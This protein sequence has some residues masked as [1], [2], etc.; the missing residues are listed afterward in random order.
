MTTDAI[1]R[2]PRCCLQHSD[3]QTLAEHLRRDFPTLESEQV[4]RSLVEAQRVTRRF[5][6][7]ESDALDVGEL[8]VRHRLMLTTGLLPDAART[9][10][11]TH[12]APVAAA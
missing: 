9:D 11:Q 7:E 6:L 3:W 8:M 4:L 1:K 10:P 2:L 5:N 12:A